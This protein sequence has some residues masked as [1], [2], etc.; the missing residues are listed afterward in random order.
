MQLFSE[1]SYR[2]LNQ[3]GEETF[4]VH[5]SLNNCSELYT[6][7]LDLGWA[8]PQLLPF[9]L[10]FQVAKHLCNSSD[11]FPLVTHITYATDPTICKTFLFMDDNIDDW[12]EHF[13]LE[14]T[15][16]PEI[17]E[18]IYT[19]DGFNAAVESL[20]LAALAASQATCLR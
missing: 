19:K 20:Q 14:L 18:F 3:R 16:L 6:S 15:L 13:N 2:I 9:V 11:H 7:T 10:E 17:P 12:I 8:S 4:F 1:N 5:R